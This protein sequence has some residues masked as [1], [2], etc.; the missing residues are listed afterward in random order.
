MVQKIKLHHETL[1]R[2][3]NFKEK[4]TQI[5][6]T[7]HAVENRAKCHQSG[8]KQSYDEVMDD[9]SDMIVARQ[10]IIFNR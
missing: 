4:T 6:R 5:V 8:F 2:E 10:Q 9:I 3:Q 7:Y 1:L